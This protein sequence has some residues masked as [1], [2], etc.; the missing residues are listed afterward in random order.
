MLLSVVGLPDILFVIFGL[1]ANTKALFAYVKMLAAEIRWA[2]LA[3]IVFGCAMGAVV[4]TAIWLT[5]AASVS[6]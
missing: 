6:L 2:T 5:G 1:F 3:I 4:L